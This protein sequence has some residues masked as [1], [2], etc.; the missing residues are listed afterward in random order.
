MKLIPLFMEDDKLRMLLLQV[1]DFSF[2]KIF[3]F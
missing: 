3:K 2:K 1:L